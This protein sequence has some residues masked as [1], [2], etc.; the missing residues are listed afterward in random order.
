MLLVGGLALTSCSKGSGVSQRAGSHEAAAVG[1]S[2]ERHATAPMPQNPR[3]I[4]ALFENEASSRPA[5]VLRAEDALAAF[6]RAG[7]ALTEQRQH[8]ARPYGARYCVGAF[9]G[10]R[11]IALSVCEYIDATAAQTGA[12][13]S[14]KISLANRE[15]RV[16][17]ATSL[18][19][20]EINKTAANDALSSRLFDSFAKL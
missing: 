19:I 12:A 15:I 10:G 13:E 18:T 1:A 2:S 16:N 20:R 6:Q 7:V 9:A 11:D 4:N 5:G 14:R 8:L 3:D 17:H